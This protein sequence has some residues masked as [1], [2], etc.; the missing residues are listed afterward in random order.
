[1][2]FETTVGGRFTILIVYA[3]ASVYVEAVGSRSLAAQLSQ[4]SELADRRILDCCRYVEA[5]GLSRSLAAQLSQSSEIADR[6]IC[7]RRNC[8]IFLAGARGR[9]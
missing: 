5:V 4:S 2:S 9:S 6:R 8:R 7:C 1:M 3:L